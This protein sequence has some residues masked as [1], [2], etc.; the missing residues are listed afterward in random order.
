MGG[1]V[2]LLSSNELHE[3]LRET[4]ILGNSINKPISN[5]Y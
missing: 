4:I 2:P 1:R 3:K 5:F